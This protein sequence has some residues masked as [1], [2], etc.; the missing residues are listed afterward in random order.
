VKVRQRL[1][2]VQTEADELQQTTFAFRKAFG[3][4]AQFTAR[5]HPGLPRFDLTD[6]V[7]PAL[8]QHNVISP[9]DYMNFE[10]G[11]KPGLRAQTLFD[12][13]ERSGPEDVQKIIKILK[14]H[15]GHQILANELQ[16][17]YNKATL[18]S[19]KFKLNFSI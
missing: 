14:K 10:I 11:E 5:K 15:R 9:N 2:K 18:T 4:E 13:L 16:A 17:M 6:E 7:Y 8:R 1:V 12:I 3:C 19:N